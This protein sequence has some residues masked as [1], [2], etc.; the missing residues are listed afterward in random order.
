MNPFYTGFEN[1]V[2]FYNQWD[3]KPR[4]L[5]LT[6]LSSGRGGEQTRWQVPFSKLLPSLNQ[7][8][9]KEP[10]RCQYLVLNLVICPAS[11]ILQICPLQYAL[12]WKPSMVV[13]L[14]WQCKQY[15]R[16]IALSQNNSCPREEDNQAQGSCRETIHLIT[17]STHQQ[18]LLRG[19]HGERVL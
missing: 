1:F 14:T 18:K 4:I 19:Q 12:G 17:S 9:L 11:C 15:Q 5:K 2:T 8:H 7:G 6:G 3:F 10:A 16:K 13:S